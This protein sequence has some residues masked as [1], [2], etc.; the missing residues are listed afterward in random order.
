MEMVDARLW[1]LR[2]MNGDTDAREY[3]PEEYADEVAWLAERA[4]AA[5]WNDG[6]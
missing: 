1:M 6:T 2:L 4:K 3:T 5:G